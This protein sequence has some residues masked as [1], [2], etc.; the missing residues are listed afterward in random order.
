[1]ASP[2]ERKAGALISGGNSRKENI[3]AVFQPAYDM[4]GL[5]SVSNRI[6]SLVAEGGL[7]LLPPERR[8]RACL[9]DVNSDVHGI[10]SCVGHGKMV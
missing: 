1:M 8:C 6:E 10:L 3:A 4:G 7:T 2:I 5:A 9:G